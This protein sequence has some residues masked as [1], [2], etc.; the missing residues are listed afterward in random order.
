VKTVKVFVD[1]VYGFNC[2]NCGR[3]LEEPS[4]GSLNWLSSDVVNT[5]RKNET[6]GLGK[7]I[8]CEHCGETLKVPA[9]IM[10]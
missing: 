9:R 7:V 5:I 10:K 2:P 3:E 1:K 4:S 6:N 8:V